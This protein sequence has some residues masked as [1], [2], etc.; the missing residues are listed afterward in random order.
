MRILIV[1]A[2]FPPHVGGVE[3]VAE[4]QAAMLAAA[5]HEVVVAT[6]RSDRALPA[7]ERIDGYTVERLPAADVVERRLRIPYPLVGVAFGRALWRLVR[8]CDAVHIHDV[9]YLPSQLAAV[10][11][12]RASKPL[13]ATQHVGPV[14]HHHRFVVAVERAV[15]AVAGGYIWRQARRVVSHNRMVHDHLRAN[16]VPPEKILPATIGIDTRRFS[17]GAAGGTGQRA[18]SGKPVALFV[19]RLV[20]KKGFHHLVRAGS[21]DYQIVAAGSGEPPVPVPDTVTCVGPVSRDDLVA[22]YRSATVFVLPSTGEMFPLVVQEAM[23]CGLPVVLT[24]DPRYDDYGIDRALLRLVPAEP[25]ALR[26]A[27][28]EIVLDPGLRAR[29]SEYSRRIAVERFDSGLSRTAQVAIYDQP[30]SAPA[31]RLTGSATR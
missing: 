2:Y 21:P 30:V 14:N 17:P 28:T 24:D 1:S 26:R 23:A 19:G 13:Y 27:V 31:S 6:T 10:F 15:N 5:G 25:A 16:G 7:R 3:V 9:L 22:W 11:A 20:Y 18:P 8:W 4:H 12:R 29:M